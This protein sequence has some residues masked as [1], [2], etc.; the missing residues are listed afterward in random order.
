MMSTAVLAIKFGGGEELSSG[1]VE[2]HPCSTYH[3]AF[4]ILENCT[5]TCPYW[6]KFKF[7]V[8]QCL[9][10]LCKYLRIGPMLLDEIRRIQQ[11]SSYLLRREEG[12]IFQ[13]I[14]NETRGVYSSLAR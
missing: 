4:H 2:H 5:G 12:L 11:F 6:K 13:E 8:K 3:S 1:T 9:V 7:F 10:V 14:R